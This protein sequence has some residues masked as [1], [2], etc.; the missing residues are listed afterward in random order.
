MNEQQINIEVNEL[1]QL[2]EANGLNESEE[3]FAYPVC[4]KVAQ[5]LN[6]DEIEILSV[7]WKAEA[8]K[9]DK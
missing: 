2:I 3:M 8:Q 6:K 7:F 1:M 4:V 9:A 5:M